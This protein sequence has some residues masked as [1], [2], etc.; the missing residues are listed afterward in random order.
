MKGKGWNERG[1][2]VLKNLLRNL[3]RGRFK[4]VPMLSNRRVQYKKIFTSEMAKV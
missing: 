1:V 2:N 4:F 3:F